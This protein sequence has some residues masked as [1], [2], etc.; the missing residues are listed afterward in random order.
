M[1][2]ST[3][4]P[5]GTV[6]KVQAINI[7]NKV[8]VKDKFRQLT[9][10][11]WNERSNRL[12]NALTSLGV[13]KGDKFAVLAYNCIEWMEI[14]AAASKGGQV[15]VPVNFR[16][17]GPEIEYIVNHSDSKAFIV[18]QEFKETVNGI[19]SHLKISESCY[20][21]FGS[22]I[23]PDG[24]RSYEELL[25]GA[26]LGEPAVSIDGEDPW[27]IMYTSGTT[28]K[29]KGAVRNHQATIAEFLI[30]IVE[31]GF[32]QDDIG[33]LVMPMCHINSVFY[34]F[35]FTYMGASCF[36]YNMTTFDPEDLLKTIEK[37][38]ITFTSLVPTH[39]IMILSHPNRDRYNVSSVRKLVC[40]SAP[41]RRSTKLE[42]MDYFKGVDFF[43]IYGSTEA[44]SVTLLRPEE[45]LNKVGSIG[46]EVMGTDRIKLLDEEGNEVPDGEVGELFA[47]TP[48][49][50]TEYWKDLEKTKQAFRGEW[51]SAGDMAKR[52]RDGYYYLVDRKANM[53]ITGGENVFPS[54]VENVVGSHPA[55]KDVAV[56]GVPH[57]KWGEAVK[58]VV[59]LKEEGEILEPELISYCKGKIAGYKVPKSVDFIK[60]EEMPRTATG[61]ILHR[62]LRERYGK[63]SDFS[64]K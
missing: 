41:V 43:E 63:W 28:G 10:K 13:G 25:A 6:M 15:A 48:E 37:E 29:P 32:R 56:I 14:Y 24:W 35:V 26:S 17:A 20:I 22:E 34:S 49:I 62:V 31:L 53:I 55:V 19:R 9:F 18:A 23:I 1:L 4:L 5:V 42:I 47:R 54:E 30:N 7:P 36:V 61:K 45:Q 52:D 27:M 57:E 39:Y 40:S 64:Q 3:W 58:A 33:L 60:D 21:S 51:F 50:F 12:A 59:I 46:K 16:L 2:R 11:E 8:A 44:G 38:R